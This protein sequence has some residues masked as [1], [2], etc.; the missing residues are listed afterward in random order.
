MNLKDIPELVSKSDRKISTHKTLPD[1]LE[2]IEQEPAEERGPDLVG[3]DLYHCVNELI[4]HPE[5]LP[6]VRK[7]VCAEWPTRHMG[8]KQR[9][10][11]DALAGRLYYPKR[12]GRV[13]QM[14]Q[15]N[16]GYTA[17]GLPSRWW[18]TNYSYRKVLTG[19]LRSILKDMKDR[20][21]I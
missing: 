3:L 17:D 19:K 20:G 5:L 18:I 11:V 8:K 4:K 6:R 7:I 15:G 14:P 9:E 13:H 2:E 21:L 16:P 12:E 1:A 10:I